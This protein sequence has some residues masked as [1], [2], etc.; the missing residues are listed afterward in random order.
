MRDFP[1]GSIWTNGRGYFRE[2]L[3]TWRPRFR[4]AVSYRTFRI[5]PDGDVREYAPNPGRC[6]VGTMSQWATRRATEDEED[7]LILGVKV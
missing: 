1:V 4:D 6:Y 3:R 5:M 2:V 7:A